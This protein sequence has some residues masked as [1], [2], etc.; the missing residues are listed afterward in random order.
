MQAYCHCHETP[1]GG[2]GFPLFYSIPRP[3]HGGGKLRKPLLGMVSNPMAMFEAKKKN[4]SG[5]TDRKEQDGK[6][7]ACRLVSF[8]R[9]T[10]PNASHCGTTTIWLGWPV[11]RTTTLHCGRPFL[12]A[13]QYG[14]NTVYPSD[15]ITVADGIYHGVK[16]SPTRYHKSCKI[17]NFGSLA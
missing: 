14:Y 17:I 8:D 4:H 6:Q 2:G 1:S 16:F 7:R 12:W 9:Y 3:H 15:D 5:H 10:R 11:R 13:Q